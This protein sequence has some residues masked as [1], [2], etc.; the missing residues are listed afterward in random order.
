MTK[1]RKVLVLGATGAMGQH[2]VPL[3]A[4]KGYQID[5]VAF[6]EKK[7]D[8]P[9]VRYLKLNVKEGDHLNR[10][11]ENNYDGIVDFMIYN[12]SELVR[13]LPRFLA[14]TGHYIY[15]SSYRVYEN[16][17]RALPRKNWTI[18]RPAITYSL[19][20]YQLVTLEAPNTVGRAFAGKPVPLPEQARGIQATMTWGG[21]V[22]RMIAGLLFNEKAVCEAFTVATSEHRTWGEIADYYKDICNLK[23][24]W[25]DEEDYLRMLSS[26]PYAYWT[27]WQLEYDRF[28][29]RVIDNSKVLTVTGMTQE[30]LKTLYDGLKYEISRCPRDIQWPVNTAM[31]Q[32]LIRN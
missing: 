6:D 30:S 13:Y 29:N 32:A 12:T 19:M 16:I 31:D 28:F 22:A 8:Y 10:L 20:R 26:D 17:L 21:D 7:S 5:G 25:V 15:L 24:V 9:N 23:A 18:I 11:L 27:R 1:P 3:L 14:N 2:L 4:E